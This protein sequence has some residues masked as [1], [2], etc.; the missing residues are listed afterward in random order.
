[1][2]DLFTSE[3]GDALQE[4][5][6]L[7]FDHGVSAEEANR[8]RDLLIREFTYQGW[9]QA[10]VL[11]IVNREGSV[12][13]GFQIDYYGDFGLYAN[14]SYIRTDRSFTHTGH[15]PVGAKDILI[16]LGRRESQLRDMALTLAMD[17]MDDWRN[18]SGQP[19]AQAEAFEK[20]KL[21]L[22]PGYTGP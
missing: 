16:V 10:R 7:H 18:Q 19:S 9:D 3:P 4:S 5:W 22:S 17:L 6:V 11:A 1:M 21:I 2:T 8:V 12:M 20:V 14:N 15:G 13:D